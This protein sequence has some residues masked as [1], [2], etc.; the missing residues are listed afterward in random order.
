MT[1]LSHIDSSFLGVASIEA[2]NEPLMNAAHTPGYGEC[3]RAFHPT[4]RLLF[5]W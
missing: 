5:V 4:L 2:V 3:M 1:V